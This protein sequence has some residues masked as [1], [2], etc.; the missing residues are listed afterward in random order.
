MARATTKLRLFTDENVPDSV[1]RYLQGRGHSV[2]RARAH[3]APSTPDQVVATT[4]MED[5]RILVSWDKDFNDQRFQKP[6]FARLSRIGLSGNG[7]DLVKAMRKHMRL[8]EFQW[9]E[10]VRLGQRRMIVFAKID[11]CRFKT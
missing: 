10:K 8:I 2:Y 1:G 9:S 11:G 6:R 7:P 5:D 3:L 4:A